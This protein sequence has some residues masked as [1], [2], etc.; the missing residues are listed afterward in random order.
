ME[1]V[2]LRGIGNLYGVSRSLL[3][4]RQHARTP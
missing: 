3:G 1:A 2:A 4:M